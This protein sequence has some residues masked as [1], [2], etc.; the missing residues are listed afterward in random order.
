MTRQRSPDALV[1]ASLL[2]ADLAAV[3]DRERD[4]IR[5]FMLRDI[6]FMFLLFRNWLEHDVR[7]PGHDI[8]LTQIRRTMD[9]L[10]AR[11]RV[12]VMPRRRSRGRLPR[13]RYALTLAGVL[14]IADS[15]VEWTPARTFEEGLFVI[16]FCTAYRSALL[17]RAEQAGAPVGKAHLART[18]EPR[19]IAATMRRALLRQRAD[20]EQRISEGEQLLEAALAAREAGASDAD[21]V[22]EIETLS[23]YQMQHVRPLGEM[24]LSLPPALRRF[25]I[26]DGIAAR[27]DLIFQPLLEHTIAQLDVL[28]HVEERI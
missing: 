16:L 19:R 20:L 2:A 1:A 28:T 27:R 9:E 10:V 13:Q 8:D 18:L 21:I 17:R 26:S 24:L 12:V 22:R 3:V 25:E 5:G 11:R 7:E 23:P 4:E 15:L 6:R 14:A